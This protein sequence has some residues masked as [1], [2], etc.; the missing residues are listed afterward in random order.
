MNRRCGPSFFLWLFLPA[1]LVLAAIA[2]FGRPEY[3]LSFFWSRPF[4]LLVKIFSAAAFFLLILRGLGR[5]LPQNVSKWV[6]GLIFLPV[7]LLPVF[8]CYF[9]VPY[10]F[11]RACPNRCPWGMLR[12][13]AFSSFILLNLSE[14]F[15]CSALCPF[16][17]LQESQIGFSKQSFKLSAWVTVLASIVLSAVAGMYLLTLWGSRWTEFFNLDRYAWV[18]GT[19]LAALGIFLVSFFIPK[20]WCRYLCPVGAIAEL[21]SNLGAKK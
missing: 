17:T 7:L 21:S 6:Y 8:S 11:C 15:W 19:A 18:G 5:K 4:L 3:I 16:G 10:V 9:K 13:F 12:T 2:Y 14:K 20:F 1:G